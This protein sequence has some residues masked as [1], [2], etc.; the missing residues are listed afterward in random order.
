MKKTHDE[1]IKELSAVLEAN[2]RWIDVDNERKQE[3]A[4]AFGWYKALGMYDRGERE[5][6]L[7]S[8]EQIFVELGRILAA[9][10][11][12]NIEGNVS[13]L[14]MRTNQIGFDV[15]ELKKEKNKEE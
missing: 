8:W 13:E 11:F 7:P 5:P 6:S 1:L 3:F 10:D 15:Q 2:K 14:E 12:R 9:R 4:K